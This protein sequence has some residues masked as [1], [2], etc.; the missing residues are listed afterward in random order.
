MKITWFQS[1]AVSSGGMP[2]MA[3][4]PPW[5]IVRSISR[6][7]CGVAGHLQADVEALLHAELLHRLV[8][9]LARDVDGARG[10]HLARQLQA[11]VV[12]VGDHHVARADEAGD[13]DGHDA[14]RAGAGDQHVL[15]DQV[16]GERGVGGVAERIEDRGDVVAD[17]S[18]AA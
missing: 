15:A 1:I 18:R 2:S 14:D 10:A 13:R 7:A 8:E 12:D 16:E 3:T 5:C 11:V 6:K 9:G 17:R 4:R